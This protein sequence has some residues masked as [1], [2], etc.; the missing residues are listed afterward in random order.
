MIPRPCYGLINVQLCVY[1]RFS[2]TTHQQESY[3]QVYVFLNIMNSDHMVEITEILH[4]PQSKFLV[5]RTTDMTYVVFFHI[6]D[7]FPVPRNRL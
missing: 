3:T 6:Y 5:P 7:Q 4:G 1:M 2:P